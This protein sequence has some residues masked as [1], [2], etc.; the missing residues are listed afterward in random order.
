[1]NKW[2]WLGS[3]HIAGVSVCSSDGM[4]LEEVDEGLQL[5]M[6]LIVD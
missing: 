1:M 4:E 5:I 6:S 3:G 2:I